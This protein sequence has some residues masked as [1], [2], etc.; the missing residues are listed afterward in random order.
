MGF[1]EDLFSEAHSEFLK[2]ASHLKDSYR[3][4]HNNIESLVN[5]YDDNREGI[6]LFHPSHM[7]NKFEDKSVAYTEQKMTLK[8]V[9]RKTFLVSALT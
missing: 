4:A 8:N 2:A 7:M 3:F 1:L 9:S 5:K 6:A